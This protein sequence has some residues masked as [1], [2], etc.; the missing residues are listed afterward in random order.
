M[1]GL[2]ARAAHSDQLTEV[3]A[4]QRNPDAG[5]LD[6]FAC[7]FLRFFVFTLLAVVALG[8]WLAAAEGASTADD[9]LLLFLLGSLMGFFAQVFA[10]FDGAY[11]RFRLVNWV[12]HLYSLVWLPALGFFIVSRLYVGALHEGFA[13]MLA[14]AFF[15]AVW[16]GSRSKRLQREAALAA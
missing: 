14:A 5:W 13:T 2:A 1:W 3:F 11:S 7:A 16:L 8:L 12:V 4:M 15:V 10:D 9:S 6:R